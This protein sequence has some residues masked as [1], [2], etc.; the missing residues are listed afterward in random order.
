MPKKLLKKYMPNHETIKTNPSLK[1]FGTLLH[2][3]NLWSLNR[4]SARSAFAV[5][6]FFAFWPVPF[7]M[8]LAA[9]LAIPMR[10]NLPL[11][12]SL[13]WITNPL[14]MPPIFY[15][16]YRVGELVL[17]ETGHE[18]AFEASW[19]WLVT[20]LSTIGPTFLAGCLICGVCFGIAGY[21]L[22]D[23]FWRLSVGKAWKSR[24]R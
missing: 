12:T 11:S 4:R 16:A 2:D 18:F 13:V 21:F 8:V 19:S 7:Q 10:A 15:G 22:V 5:G 17:G 23:I 1:V 6:L 24:N 20:S 14:T 9:A 3:S